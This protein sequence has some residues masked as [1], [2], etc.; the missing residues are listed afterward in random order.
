MI[1][2]DGDALRVLVRQSPHQIR[3][4]DRGAPDDDPRHAVIEKRC[5]AHAPARLHR[6]GYGAGDGHHDLAVR[7]GSSSR[8]EIDDVNP[9]RA[10]GL[11]RTG[12]RD[13]VVVVHGLAVEV[14]LMQ[15]HH[16]ASA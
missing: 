12:D 11:E 4:L 10:R 16:A 8:I 14:A 6:Y 9:R 7:P 15:S 5:V 2:A 13:G 1:E 3:I